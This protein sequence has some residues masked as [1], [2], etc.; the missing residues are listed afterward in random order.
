MTNIE[1]TKPNKTDAGNGS[2]AIC[3]VSNVLR[4]PSP[5]PS[6]SPKQ[7]SP[8]PMRLYLV[9][10]LTALCSCAH[11]GEDREL[12]PNQFTPPAAH[13]SFGDKKPFLKQW[14]DFD[15][16]QNAAVE[17]E[18]LVSWSGRKAVPGRSL[19]IHLSEGSK[20]ENTTAHPQYFEVW[21]Q[22][23]E[24]VSINV[25]YRLSPAARV[26]AT[27][28]VQRWKSGDVTRYSQLRDGEMTVSGMQGY[29][30][31][32]LGGSWSAV[33]TLTVISRSTDHITFRLA[34]RLPI[35]QDGMSQKF[36]YTL[37]V[38]RE[39]KAHYKTIKG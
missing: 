35:R 9:P 31:P 12:V 6:R 4:S 38:D 32:E 34:G 21:I 7:P 27:T 13:S 24:D 14:A 19:A 23:P 1:T 17:V 11:H 37:K 22:I 15:A 33:A 10:V 18:H 39:Y 28:R 5:D 25:P 2:K 3:R 29:D 20:I 36:G 26:R 16:F 30:V 8:P